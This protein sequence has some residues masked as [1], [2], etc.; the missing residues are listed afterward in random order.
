MQ[1]LVKVDRDGPGSGSGAL[2]CGTQWEPG[3]GLF[4]QG[5]FF[6]FM[7]FWAWNPGFLHVSQALYQLSNILHLSGVGR[8]AE[9]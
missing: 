6:M 9:L 3:L 4:F 1:G 2:D 8:L 5:L 7:G